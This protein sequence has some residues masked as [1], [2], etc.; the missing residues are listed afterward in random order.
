MGE[1]LH[2]TEFPT[3]DSSSICVQVDMPLRH[4]IVA[5]TLQVDQSHRFEEWYEDNTNRLQGILEEQFQKP[6]ITIDARQVRRGIQENIDQ[7]KQQS[8]HQ[9]RM[10]YIISLDP[11]M[12]GPESADYV[13]QESRVSLV[14][15]NN[16]VIDLEQNARGYVNRFVD[17]VGVHNGAGK[18][19]SRQMKEIQG[20]ISAHQTLAP[21]DVALV[22]GYANSGKSIIERFNIPEIR[23]KHYNALHVIL[24]ALNV[25]AAENFKD[26]DIHHHP[27]MRFNSEPAKCIDQTDMLP[28]LGGRAIGW[29]PTHKY[30]AVSTHVR[31]FNVGRF[32]VNVMTAVDAITGNYPW[33]VDLTDS[34]MTPEFRRKLM[35]YSVETAY[36]FWSSLENAGGDELKWG[37]L[38]VLNGIMR[39]FY[40]AHDK[41]DLN[42]LRYPLASGPVQAIQR[43][44]KGEIYE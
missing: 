33:Q 37:D 11:V 12:A 20:I 38:T 16:P 4:Q 6:V 43:I 28:T 9:E 34:E 21:I 18:T 27:L 19:M 30:E 40:P 32:A 22:D 2:Q 42:E 29:R 8:F 13:F 39:F 1:S 17:K 36:S 15:V 5:Q 35:D 44:M 14:D 3:I 41:Q 26:V 24:G 10:P 25:T 31:P 23:G 7:F